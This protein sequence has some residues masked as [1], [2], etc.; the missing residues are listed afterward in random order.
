[1]EGEK[2]TGVALTAYRAGGGG[3]TPWIWPRCLRLAHPLHLFPV[4]TSHAKSLSRRQTTPRHLVAL[5]SERGADTSC[6]QIS[7][8]RIPDHRQDSF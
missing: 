6:G 2:I 1:M 8:G 4:Q 5:V 7:G 3:E